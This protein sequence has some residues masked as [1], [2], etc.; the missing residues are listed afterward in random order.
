MGSP[1]NKYAGVSK[2]AN[3]LVEFIDQILRALAPENEL[4]TWVPN[5]PDPQK[6]VYNDG[7]TRRARVL[8]AARNLPANETEL[9]TVQ[10]ENIDNVMAA[11][12]KTAQKRKHSTS[13][14]AEIL[15][16]SI[17]IV[18]GLMSLVLR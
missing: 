16:S 14:D 13:K 3:S 17:V 7:Y 5:Q 6:Y 10:A 12:Q 2:A 15:R 8:Y 1:H 9:V 18:T 11:I 4:A